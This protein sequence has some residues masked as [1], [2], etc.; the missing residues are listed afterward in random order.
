MIEDDLKK[1]KDY[2]FIINIYCIFTT[3]TKHTSVQDRFINGKYIYTLPNGESFDVHI[4]YWE[5][6]NPKEC[7][8]N[9]VL[10]RY[11]PILANERNT[12]FDEYRISLNALREYIPL[13]ITY[14]NLNWLEKWD[15]S[16]AYVLK[17]DYDVFNNLFFEYNRTE[18][19]LKYEIREFIKVGNRNKMGETLLAGKDFYD[20]LIEFRNSIESHIIGKYLDDGKDAL[21]LEELP[22]EFIQKQIVNWI[23]AAKRLAKVYRKD[24]LGEQI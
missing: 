1:T 4:F 16:C 14:E 15:F 11:F 10:N 3:G 2:P 9:Q 12:S 20:A 23:N 6:I 22:P 18:K 8:P 13:Y 21:V 7:I 19:S 24:I 5:D 17:A